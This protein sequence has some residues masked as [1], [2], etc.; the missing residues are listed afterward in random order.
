MIPSD[1]PHLIFAAS[2]HPGMT[3]KQNEDRYGVTAF[4]GGKK[5]TTPSVLAVLCDGIGG[6]RAGEVAAEMGVSIITKH[7]AAGEDRQP[8]Q[9]MAEAIARASAA[10]YEASQADQGRVGMGATCA[11]AW[12][13][14]DW[15]YTANL[16]DSRIYL[17]RKGNLL[18]LTT[19][20][21]WIQEAM[22][23]GLITDSN[24]SNHINAHVIRRY[25]GSPK[26]PEPD[27]RLWFFEGEDDQAA[28]DNQGLRLQPNDILLLCSDGLTDLVSDQEIRE[29]LETAAV[30]DAPEQL[31]ALANARGG[32]DNTTIVLLQV[33]S[34]GKIAPGKTRKRRWA[35]GCVAGLAVVSLLVTAILLGLRWQKGELFPS[36]KPTE[37]PRVTV[38]MPMES[39]GTALPATGVVATPTIHINETLSDGAPATVTTAQPTITPW[40]TNSVRP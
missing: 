15:L 5:G 31:I 28:L 16:G 22:D 36:Q 27:F 37:E 24:N 23:A 35:L 25:L 33:P 32:H 4:R 30:T 7:I 3:G 10:V 40:P 11:C 38:T 19:D 14:A 17:L 8:L 9:I 34:R 12:V 13:I 21:T 20:H 26:P 29:V 1:Q 39:P 6:H 2:T 18:Q